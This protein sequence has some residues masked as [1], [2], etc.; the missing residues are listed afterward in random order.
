[1]GTQFETSPASPT[2]HALEGRASYS[3]HFERYKGPIG[4]KIWYGVSHLD[5]KEMSTRCLEV[6]VDESNNR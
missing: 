4:L 3:I 1:M 6:H 2:E 5:S